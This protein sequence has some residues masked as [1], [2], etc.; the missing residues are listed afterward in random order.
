M[1]G[2]GDYHIKW[3]KSE[4]ERWGLH[5]FSDCESKKKRENRRES[6]I[7]QKEGNKWK[8]GVRCKEG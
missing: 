6:V 5:V 7:K 8:M 2:T 1:D 4:S 3:N